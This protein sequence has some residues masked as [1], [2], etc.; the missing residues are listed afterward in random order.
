MRTLVLSTECAQER[1]GI[2]EFVI[3]DKKKEF[4]FLK[5]WQRPNASM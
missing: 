4:K 2:I 5:K 3:F 1:K